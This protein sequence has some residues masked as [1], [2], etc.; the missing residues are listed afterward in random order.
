MI[1]VTYVL[2]Y[3]YIRFVFVFQ[4]NFLMNVYIFVYN[5]I[6][7]VYIQNLI[8]EELSNKIKAIVVKIL[9]I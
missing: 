8:V 9:N 2:V 3:L 4:D 6:Q 7:F 1:D 5:V